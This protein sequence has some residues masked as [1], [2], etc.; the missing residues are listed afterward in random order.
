MF[1]LLIERDG[2][3]ILKRASVAEHV[4]PFCDEGCVAE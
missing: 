1:R 2:A 4:A 3:G